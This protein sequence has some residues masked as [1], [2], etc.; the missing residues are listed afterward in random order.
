M[1][2]NEPLRTKAGLIGVA[3]LLSL[4]APATGDVPYWQCA[5][6]A[7]SFSGIEIYGD[8]RT[9]WS[10]AEGR[11]VRGSV[12]RVGSV[13][14]FVPSGSMR[15]GHV[16]TVTRLVSPREIT[17][18]HANWSPID[19]RRGRIERDVRV[20]DASIANDWSSVQVWFAPIA[21]LGTTA[22]PVAGFIHPVS[23]M[24]AT[25]RLQYA[26]LSRIE[27]GSRLQPLSRDILRLAS[28]E[29]RGFDR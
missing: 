6:F 20:R 19:G 12:P 4:A 23:Q 10:Q 21:D 3:A 16:A 17:V 1:E 2:G 5:T 27:P 13:M 22:W 9:W 24:R 15:L 8:A 7:R 26:D 25:P 11:F 14:A 29:Q 28:L 18:T